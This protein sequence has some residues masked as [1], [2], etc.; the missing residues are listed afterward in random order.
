MG[1]TLENNGCKSSDTINISFTTLPKF[2]LG[3]DNLLCAGNTLILRPVGDFLYPLTWQDGSV[4]KSIVVSN[5]G[6]YSASYTNLCGKFNDT[7]VIKNG[8]C[9][10][11]VP[12]AFTP[13]GDGKNDFFRIVGNTIDKISFQIYSRWGQKL[14]ETNNKSV[15]WD[16]NF[17]GIMQNADA[18]VYYVQYT[19]T[20]EDKKYTMK[21]TLILLR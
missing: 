11:L 18:Y 13:N 16:G 1:C 14:F 3:P 4:A 7:I 17:H 19:K 15:G 10:I 9:E 8:V 21:G 20:G 5:S 12:D 2:S 6:E